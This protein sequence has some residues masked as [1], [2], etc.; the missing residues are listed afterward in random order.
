M[1]NFESF[2]IG[3][4]TWLLQGEGSK[5]EREHG[6]VS[7][8][9]IQPRLTITHK[10]NKTI[11]SQDHLRVYVYNSNPVSFIERDSFLT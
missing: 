3:K 4:E 5:H 6:T 8:S 11:I 1:A 9:H 10:Q 7:G 2:R